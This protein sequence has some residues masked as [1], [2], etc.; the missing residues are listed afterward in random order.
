MKEMVGA[1]LAFVALGV[2]VMIGGA[3]IA[4]TENVTKTINPSDTTLIETL[5]NDMESALTTLTSLLPI[6]ALAIIGG[7]AL[8]YV[9]GFVRT[10]Q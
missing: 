10:Q 9:L 5:G 3:M 1:A 7:L 6:L 4:K 2:V 8:A